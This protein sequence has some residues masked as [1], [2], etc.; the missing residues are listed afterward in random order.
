MESSPLHHFFFVKCYIDSSRA[1]ELVDRAEDLGISTPYLLK[2]A[3][4]EDNETLEK[5]GMTS[6]DAMLTLKGLDSM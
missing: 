5:L 6:V 2:M 1:S 4:S 3:L